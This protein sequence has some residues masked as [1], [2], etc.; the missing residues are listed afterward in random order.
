MQ[1]SYVTLLITISLSGIFKDE[2]AFK[3]DTLP[4]FFFNIL[5]CKSVVLCTMVG[6]NVVFKVENYPTLTLLIPSQLIP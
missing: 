3:W 1:L 2:S 5:E 6:N 4:S